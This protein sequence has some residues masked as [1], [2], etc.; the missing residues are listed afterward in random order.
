M[1]AVPTIKSRPKYP[2]ISINDSV[3]KHLFIA[4]TGAFSELSK[5]IKLCKNGTKSYWVVGDN[6]SENLHKTISTVPTNQ[7]TET[8]SNVF[9]KLP[10]SSNIYVAAKTEAFLWDIHNLAIKAGLADE[11]IKKLKPLT[12]QRRLFCTHCYT[13]TNG[14]T[15]S[16]FKCPGCHRQLL[17]RDH[18]STLHSAYVGV[19][20]NA[21]DPDDIPK[22]EELS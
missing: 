12:N 19:Q 1:Q 9:A 21:E 22:I 10:F 14:V 20:I 8:F 13:I 15:Y 2:P 16:P 3:Q 4:E 18:F 17:V 5:V 11:Q 7:I 6:I